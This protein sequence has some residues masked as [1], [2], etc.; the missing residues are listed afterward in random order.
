MEA[1]S[2]KYFAFSK[3]LLIGLAIFFVLIISYVSIYIFI[4]LKY[5]DKIYSNVYIGNT[6]L[7]GL[8][9]DEAE[10]VIN[11]KADA[12]KM[13]GITFNYR[14]K[15]NNLELLFSSEND[16]EALSIIDFNARKTAE[17]AFAYGRNGN[18]Y[19][20]TFNKIKGLFSKKEINT[21]LSINE[22][23]I[24]KYL[25]ETFSEFHKPA[26]DTKMVITNDT[27]SIIEEKFGERLNS[28]EAIK[29][30]G[31]N[32]IKL[33]NPIINL[34]ITKDQPKIFK[35][36]AL[37]I[38]SSALSI[39]SR[40]PLILKYEDKKW[41]INKDT[42]SVWLNLKQSSNSQ[43]NNKITVGLDESITKKYLTNKLAPEIDKPPI[44]SKFTVKNGKVSEF[45]TNQDGLGL[46]IETS[47]QKIET[48][49]I[50]N[51]SST[52]DLVT[53][54]LKSEVSG[55]NINDFGIKEKIGTGYSNFVG[56]P[57]NRRHNIATGANALNGILVKPG[58]EFSTIKTLVPIDEKN[59]YLQELVIKKNKTTPEYGGGLCQIGTTL[60]RA[61][62]SAGLPITARRNHS[63]RVS[64]Y[65]PPVGMDATIY[66]PWPDLK[67]INDTGNYILIQASIKGNDLRFDL[68]GTKDGR[69]AST[70][71]PVISNITKPQPKKIIET[72]DLKPGEKKIL[73]KAHNG[74]DAYFKYSVTYPNSEIKETKYTSHYV[75]WQEVWLLGVEKLSEP[76]SASST[77]TTSASASQT[78][79]TSIPKTN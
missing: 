72:L 62:L 69:V 51:S 26:E 22:E 74:A 9:V 21:S 78:G 79:T 75:P 57:K 41:T 76:K 23:A 45:Q 7:S 60:F 8:S 63:Y 5:K 6:K 71:K 30:L 24:K 35:K 40:A 77:P 48:E 3:W 37:N 49:F 33:E 67:F 55:E 66:D 11:Q 27:V 61:I 36:D 47:F 18:F 58:E 1:P 32:L 56:S 50:K 59:G 64:Y 2:G 65:E 42:L 53:K 52:I 46:D 12:I 68:W 14:N 38:E 31:L 43:N 39:L 73:E 10:A 13:D 44:E 25:E 17:E 28:E 19:S 70:T 20:N 16:G 34:S 15:K 29:R 54:V 4:E